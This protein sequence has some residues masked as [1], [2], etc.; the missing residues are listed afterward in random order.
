MRLPWSP[1]Q[2]YSAAFIGLPHM[3]ALITVLMLALFL[4]KSVWSIV[5][6]T[7]V[8]DFITPIA[9]KKQYGRCCRYQHHRNKKDRRIEGG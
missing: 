2:R 9:R 7:L 4:D 8:E 1:S 5:I 6:E 3:F